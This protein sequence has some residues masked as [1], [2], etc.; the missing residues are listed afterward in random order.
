MMYLHTAPFSDLAE[1]AINVSDPKIGIH[2]PLPITDISERDRR[3]PF[4][5]EKFKGVEI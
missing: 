2:W 1:A 3:H 4:I 5:T